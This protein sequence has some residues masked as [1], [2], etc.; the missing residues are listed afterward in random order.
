[1][2]LGLNSGKRKRFAVFQNEQ[3]LFQP[4][5]QWVPGS[6]PVVEAAGA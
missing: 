3:T 2:M 4:T 1:M 5:I 6:F